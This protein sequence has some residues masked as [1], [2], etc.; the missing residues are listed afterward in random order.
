MVD[1]APTNWEIVAGVKE[2]LEA[3]AA[4]V[5][6]FSSAVPTGLIVMEHE[7]TITPARLQVG[8]EV[9]SVKPESRDSC[10]KHDVVFDIHVW[11]TGSNTATAHEALGRL[12]EAL[13]N[14]NSF[15]AAKVSGWGNVALRNIAF[16]GRLGQ[17]PLGDGWTLASTFDSLGYYY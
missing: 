1:R 3:D 11:E 7:A 10:P 9:S 2:L 4:L 6:W 12:E 15:V 16:A 14:K 5:L 17:S 8:V 13:N